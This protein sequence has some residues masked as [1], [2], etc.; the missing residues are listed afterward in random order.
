MV[1]QKKTK[2]PVATSKKKK[3]TTSSKGKTRKTSPERE[4]L[5]KADDRRD[6]VGKAG[7]RAATRRKGE[8]VG[9]RKLNIVEVKT[10]KR[11][12]L[13]TPPAPSVEALPTP[14]EVSGLDLSSEKQ[15]AQGNAPQVQDA[16]KQT[17][18]GR[19]AKPKIQQNTSKKLS[20]ISAGSDAIPLSDDPHTRAMADGRR[21]KHT[22]TVAALKKF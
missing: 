10:P 6:S 9:G 11:K 18:K 2:K 5:M 3:L 21:N 17:F 8:P 16:K 14:P 20:V 4:Q 12:P 22:A 13:K 7:P 15:L 1:I 19:K